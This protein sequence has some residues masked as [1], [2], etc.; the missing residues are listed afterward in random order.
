MPLQ[1]IGDPYPRAYR[2]FGSLNF[3]DVSVNYAPYIQ[4]TDINL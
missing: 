1:K 2:L 3:L 4:K